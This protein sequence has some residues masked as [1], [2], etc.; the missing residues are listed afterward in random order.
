MIGKPKYICFCGT[1]PNPYHNNVDTPHSC[2]QVCG[3]QRKNANLN[4]NDCHHKCT[5]LCHP[6]P[7]PQC[8][9]QVLRLSFNQIYFPHYFYL[10]KIN[11]I[12]IMCVWKKTRIC[13]M[14]TVHPDCMQQCLP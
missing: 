6:G 13:S 3:L 1:L 11:F 14:W 10:N 8:V 2:G 7:C 4:Y 12:Q 5:L 9:V